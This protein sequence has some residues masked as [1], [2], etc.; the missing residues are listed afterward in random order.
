[1]CEHNFY[2]LREGTVF[3]I[4][5]VFVKQERALRE[6]EKVL[7]L[8]P[9]STRPGTRKTIGATRAVARELKTVLFTAVTKHYKNNDV[10]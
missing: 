2:Y 7:Y 9:L 3:L 1:M 5:T 10:D 8:G 6:V 4:P